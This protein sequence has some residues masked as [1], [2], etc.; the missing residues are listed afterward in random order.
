MRC[1]NL[2]DWNVLSSNL[3]KANFGERQEEADTMMQRGDTLCSL[4]CPSWRRE[5]VAV[6]KPKCE[7]GEHK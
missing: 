1:D 3:F 2:E 5:G 7:A 4:S 6:P